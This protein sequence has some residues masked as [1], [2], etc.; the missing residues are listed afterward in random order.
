MLKKN[1]LGT[2]NPHAYIAKPTHPK[3]VVVW[4]RFWSRGIIG[5][6]FFRKWPGVAV[7]HKISYTRYTRY[8]QMFTKIEK[9]EGGYRTVLR[10]TQPK[11]HLLFCALFLK[12]TLSAT[13][14]MAFGHHQA[15]L[16]LLDYYLWDVVKDQ[17]YADKLETKGQYS[18]GRW[19][20]TAAQ[21][22]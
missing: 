10:V 18:W 1:Y 7:T 5:P 9:I 14:V 22:R 19:C 20:N 15:I 21:N 2:E 16:T 3:W 17:C 11:L 6:F 4:W 13:E 8:T 12:I